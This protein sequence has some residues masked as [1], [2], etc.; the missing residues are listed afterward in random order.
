MSFFLSCSHQLK[1]YTCLHTQPEELGD[2]ILQERTY[3]LNWVGCFHK[4]LSSFPAPTQLSVACSME[5]W[6]KFYHVSDIM[7][8]GRLYEFGQ[9]VN[10]NW[11]HQHALHGVST[12]GIS[13]KDRSTHMQLYCSSVRG[14]GFYKNVRQSGHRPVS[15]SCNVKHICDPVLIFRCTYY[16]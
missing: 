5:G 16:R 4:T 11:F 14:R 12:Q 3:N 10:H 2:C 15:L 7:D 9:H 1:L 13:V 8:R 6:G